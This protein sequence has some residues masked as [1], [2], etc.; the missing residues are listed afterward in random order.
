MTKDEKSMRKDFLHPIDNEVKIIVISFKNASA[1][2]IIHYFA[3]NV[4]VL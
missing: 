2:L 1:V 4:F 3:M